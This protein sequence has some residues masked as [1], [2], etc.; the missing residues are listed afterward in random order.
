M[1]NSEENMESYYHLA[2]YYDVLMDDVDYIQWC[3]FIEE[4]LSV[5]DC[6]PHNILDTACGT[7][8][9]TIPLASKGYNLWG[10][11]ISEEMLTIAENKARS[12]KHNIKFINQ[13]MTDLTLNKS[14]DA[15]LCM[16]DGVNYIVEE[17]DLV[18]YFETVNNMINTGGI[19]IFDISSKYKL[20]NILGNNT[21][22]Q[23]KDDF[24]YI[25]E[26][27]FDEEEELLEM[28]LNFFIPQQELY[29]RM[30]EYHIQKAYSEEYLINL[31]SEA[32]FQ[33]IR[34]FD[35]MKLEKP[36]NK[37]ERIFFAAQK[38]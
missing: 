36:N 11:D 12:K 32:G 6:K 26:N 2:E 25:W 3:N 33:N 8:N 21:L 7:G 10:V 29:K 35:D 19:F 31:L 37:S 4:I 22:F 13:N 27:C 28:R 5:Y 18:K 15:I 17:K 16:C 34:C 23:E 24:C 38:L 9:I 14:F 20:T 1:F 30:E